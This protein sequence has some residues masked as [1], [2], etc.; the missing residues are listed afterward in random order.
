VARR[1]TA[2]AC[3]AVLGNGD[4]LTLV[5]TGQ[6][7]PEGPGRSDFKELSEFFCLLSSRSCVFIF[8]IKKSIEN[9]N[10]N[11]KKEDLEEEDQGQDERNVSL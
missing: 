1:L 4:I 3:R 9:K 6:H 5:F 7:G 8:K 11:S 10:Y 2:A